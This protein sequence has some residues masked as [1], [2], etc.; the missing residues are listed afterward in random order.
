MYDNVLLRLSLTIQAHY[1]NLVFKG[2]W[3]ESSIERLAKR[4]RNRDDKIWKRAISNSF[5]V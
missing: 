1:S 5:L 2:L 3:S 4:Y